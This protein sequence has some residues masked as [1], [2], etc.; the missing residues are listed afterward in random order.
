MRDCI[1]DLSE[2]KEREF[3]GQFKD[4]IQ[5]VAAGLKAGYSVENAIRGA[6]RDIEPL[7]G[8]DK[9]I[10]REFSLMTRQLDM[11]MSTGAVLDEFAGRTGQEDVEN[12][13]NVFAAAKKSGGDSIAIIRNA[14][15]LISDRIDTEKEIRTMIASQ[16]LE[17]DI[18]CVVPFAIILYMKATFGEFLGALYGN[19]AGVCVMTVCL[20]LYVAAYRTGRKIIR[21]EV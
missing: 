9:R 1:A 14:V 11:N 20:L 4:S 7:Y 17:F 12:F 19:A 3:L 8:P 13:V 16:K 2:K 15:Q 6:G 10:C 18:M 5:A 21:I